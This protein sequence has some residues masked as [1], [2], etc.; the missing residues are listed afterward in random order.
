MSD[1]PVVIGVE[2]D[3]TPEKAAKLQ[4]DWVAAIKANVQVAHLNADL[5]ERIANLENLL[6]PF[7]EA[8]RLHLRDDRRVSEL[9]SVMAMDTSV[10]D[11]RLAFVELYGE[12]VKE[13]VEE[14][15]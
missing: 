10:E 5:Q 11:W 1:I 7:A 8:Y 14:V 9:K 13:P 15:K 6:R 3:L 2:G 4:E 12:M